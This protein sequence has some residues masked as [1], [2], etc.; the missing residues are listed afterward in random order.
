MKF[1]SATPIKT[2]LYA[3]T[4]FVISMGNPQANAAEIPLSPELQK[5][6][7]HASHMHQEDR[8]LSIIPVYRFGEVEGYA[9]RTAELFPV[10]GYGGKPIDIL[11]GLSPK[12]HYTGFVVQS[13][14]EPIF[15]KGDGP[16]ILTRYMEQLIDVPASNNIYIRGDNQKN[17]EGSG[18]SSYIDGIT[19]ATVTTS[20]I[21]QTIT[22]A[23]RSAARAKELAGYAPLNR[24]TP[25]TDK[26][27]PMSFQQLID[28]GLIKHWPIYDQQ[29]KTARLDKK[30]GYPSQPVAI[31]SSKPLAEL[32]FVYLSHPVV[33]RNLLPQA[34]YALWQ[35][36]TNNKDQ[37]LLVLSKGNWNGDLLT[38]FLSIKQ[39]GA[40]VIRHPESWP[41]IVNSLNLPNKNWDEKRLLRLP[42][43]SAFDPLTRTELLFT[44]STK[45]KLKEIYQLPTEYFKLTDSPEL[46]EKPLWQ[47]IWQQRQD[48]IALLLL[49]LTLLS[50]IFLN[51]HYFVQQPNVFHKIRWS[52]LG[53]T[54]LFIGIYAQGQLSIV[55]V[56]TFQHLLLD[57][58]SLALFLL[59]P[60]IFI[61]G[62]Y[63]LL[64][65][66]LFGRGLFCGWL[67][68][69]GALQEFMGLISKKLSI[70]QWKIKPKWHKQ[71]QKIKYLALVVILSASFFSLTYGEV[72]AELEPFKTSITLYF[73]REWQYVAYALLLL[74]LALK[75]HKFYCRY[76]C[77]LGACLAVL[78]AIP[79]FN[80]LTRRAECGYPC[81]NCKM[82]CEI[83]A[84]NKQGVI[85]MR[86]CVQCLECIVIN[87]NPAL[88]AI[89][90]AETKKQKR[91]ANYIEV[92]TS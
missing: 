19:N 71:L 90:V 49:G 64:S 85:N 42:Q 55:N 13:H 45:A 38:N 12:G 79:V 28:K 74:I 59:D 32:F 18:K 72:L 54:L 21:N 58:S 22:K 44:A 29:I 10:R 56:L 60:I 88:C 24:S 43:V 57:G 83:D 20:A 87:S 66:L 69:F 8:D 31:E 15:V 25:R 11:I 1:T 34:E 75:T 5:L 36:Q 63:V 73:I 62:C 35:E 30:L 9:F 16:Q 14:Y 39:R 78:G 46:H 89:E 26:F 70:P 80:W 68:P 67:C 48:E 65:L 6:F 4:L 50:I 23:A 53:F 84:I 37:Y 86:E 33:A 51:Q 47:Q 61:L 40:E 77:P 52:Y 81:Q 91:K 92:S 41:A 2:V 7:P 82:N 3:L 76:L 17:L 27:S